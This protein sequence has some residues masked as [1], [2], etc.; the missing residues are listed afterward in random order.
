M[1]RSRTTVPTFEPSSHEQA[2]AANTIDSNAITFLV[3]PAGTG[4]S[5][6]AAAKAAMWLKKNKNG[7]IVIARPAVG[8]QE[9]LGYLPGTREEKIEPFLKP[10]LRIL[11]DLAD[12]DDGFRIAMNRDERIEFA[13]FEHMRGE[14]YENAFVILDEA[15]NTTKEQ[16]KMALTRLGQESKMVV[17][18]D[19]DQCDLRDPSDSGLIDALRRFPDI[20][21]IETVKLTT[22]AS[23]HRHP[24]VSKILMGYSTR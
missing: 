17:T 8:G 12:C 1:A 21:G 2:T 14:T 18:G 15:Q 7:R 9:H 22:E 16:M 6:I 23:N 10:I 4:K 11:A 19:L 3:G 20:D 5:H 13:T 24:I